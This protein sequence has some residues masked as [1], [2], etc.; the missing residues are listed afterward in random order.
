MNR[1][2]ELVE[3]IVQLAF[4]Q[5][6]PPVKEFILHKSPD[7]DCWLCDYI[8]KKKI[9]KTANAKLV[10][11]NAGESRP[12]AENDPTRLVFD[13]GMGKND[14]HGK[15]GKERTCS[16]A[17]LAERIDALDDPGL[18]ALLEM[19]TAVDNIEPLPITSIHYVIEGYPRLCKKEGKVD[20]QM[21]EGKVF[22]LFDIIYNQE[23]QRAL[24]R[25]KFQEEV[26][27]I[28]LSNGLKVAPLYWCP[29]LRE[30]AFEAG[31]DV[32]I[33][34]A[35]NGHGFYVGIQRSRRAP[36]L[37]LTDVCAA[38]RFE[39]ARMRRIPVSNL[40]LKYI[41]KNGPVKNWY[42]HDSLG[43]VLSGSRS[44]ELG[45]DEFT[46]LTPRQIVATATHCLGLIPTK[47]VSEWK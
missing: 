4:D 12:G 32:V 35:R 26:R 24:S 37:A 34:T 15:G 9:A 25:T 13:T 18:K 44:W 19:V 8:A 5:A 43:L 21:V 45:K 14:Q 1:T 28:P 3:R 11:V 17:I 20:W 38:L 41:G 47:K 39:E 16:A 27:L 30:A 40:N 46:R 10:F 36:E 2:E 23:V 33:W 42:L 7:D 29:G 6:A 31:A 22:E